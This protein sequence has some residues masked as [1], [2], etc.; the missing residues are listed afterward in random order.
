M[1]V[2]TWDRLMV[3]PTSCRGCSPQMGLQPTKV[4]PSNIALRAR[5]KL[6]S[7]AWLLASWNVRSRVDVEGSVQTARSGRAVIDAEDRRVDQVLHVLNNYKIDIGALQETKWFGE[8][9][10]RVGE[11]IVLT[12]GRKTPGLNEKKTRG[13]DVAIVLSGPAKRAWRG[14]GNQ[15]K[16]WS[17]R[18]ITATLSVGSHRCDHLH[19][20]SCYAPTFRASREKDKFYDDLQRALS[21]TPPQECY[22]VHGDFNARVGSR[23]ER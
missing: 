19:I 14:G 5:Q 16:A 15:W 11:S 2:G 6:R 21:S 4:E 18:L 1:S 17:S 3:P 23:R 12:S 10:Y 8:E 13:E 22:V 20:L 7:V 9:V